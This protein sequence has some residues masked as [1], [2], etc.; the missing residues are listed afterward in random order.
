MID[1]TSLCQHK[2]YKSALKDF[3]SSPCRWN[4]FKK[5]HIEV[6]KGR[7]P[8]CECILDETVTRTTN[9]GKEKKI[10][11]T[12]DH[13]RPQ[14]Y[15]SFLKCNHKNYILMCSECNIEYKRSNFPLH[16][17]TPKRAI[18]ESEIENEKPLITNPIYDNVL[19][20]FILVFRQSSSGKRVL[21]LEPKESKGYLNEKAIETIKLF[22]LGDCDN[23]RHHND[24]IH[25]CRLEILESHFG[26]FY[27][28]A[29]A[30]RIKD[31]NRQGRVLTSLKT[32]INTCKKYGFLNFLMKNQFDIR[33][34][35]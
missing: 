8:I 2:Y 15:Y 22:G 33:L 10:E 24:N 35:D 28:V 23:N 27:E 14:Q 3:N 26:V 19:N 18:N 5:A 7:C 30:F 13:Y 21:E 31:K 11:P 9:S 16:N 12:I 32:N 25:R 6:A 17:S 34:V 29:K 20:L 4:L 1:M